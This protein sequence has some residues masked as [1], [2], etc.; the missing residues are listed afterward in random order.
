MRAEEVKRLIE[1]GLPGSIVE[2]NGDDGVHFEAVII[3]EAFDDKG[4]LAQHR[5]VYAA[6]G[7]RMH[8]EIHALSMRTY[9]PLEWGKAHPAKE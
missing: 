1:V 2:V 8:A 5:M 3:S 4:M 6:L 7:D 9:T